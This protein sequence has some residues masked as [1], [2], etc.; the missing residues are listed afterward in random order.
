M[1]MS[2]LNSVEAHD[3]MAEVGKC[4]FWTA[5]LQ[6]DPLVVSLGEWDVRERANMNELHE[7]MRGCDNAIIQPVGVMA[8][9]VLPD[10]TIVCFYGSMSPNYKEVTE[11][12]TRLWGWN[13]ALEKIRGGFPPIGNREHKAISEFKSGFEAGIAETIEK[14]TSTPYERDEQFFGDKA[15]IAYELSELAFWSFQKSYPVDSGYRV[16]IGEEPTEGNATGRQVEITVK[17]MN[18]A[19]SKQIAERE[20]KRKSETPPRTARPSDSAA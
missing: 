4:R 17:H 11:H 9:I 5:I 10:G 1:S 3:P 8:G 6:D 16:R 14:L 7:V 20:E 13:R 18:A 2:M 15:D 12:G 19:R